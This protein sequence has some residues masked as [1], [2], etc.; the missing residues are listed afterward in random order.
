MYLFVTDTLSVFRAFLASEAE[1]ES[2][3]RDMMTLSSPPPPA[4]P[5][6]YLESRREESTPSLTLTHCDLAFLL[7]S[8]RRRRRADER[9][10]R[11]VPRG[12]L[13]GRRLVQGASGRCRSRDT[14]QTPATGKFNSLLLLLLWNQLPQITL[15]TLGSWVGRAAGPLGAGQ[16]KQKSA[17]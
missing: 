2:T 13:P 11:H 8:V 16:T 9:Q 1:F 6:R 14:R 5:S 15:L 12:R 3:K 17:T 4:W 10:R 7:A